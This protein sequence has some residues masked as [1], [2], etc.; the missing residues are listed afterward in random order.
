[1]VAEPPGVLIVVANHD[2]EGG[3][4][5][6]VA[7]LARHQSHRRPVVVLT[8]APTPLPSV[9]PDPTGAIVVR[10]PCL[11]SWSTDRDRVWAS[12]NTAVSVVTAVTAAVACRRR[13]SVVY[14]AGL[15]PE[16]VVAAM[17]GRMLRRSYILDTWLP[18]PIGNVARLRRSPVAP[19]LLRLVGGAKAFVA[20]TAE[21]AGELRACGLPSDRVLTVRQGV[22][23]DHFHPV[24]VAARRRSA[25]DLVGNATG[26]VA[27]CG[28]IDLRQKRLDLL[29]DAWEQADLE[30]WSLVLAGD[31]PDAGR[32]VS[33]GR[34]MTRPPV[35]LGWRRDVAPVLAGAD[36]YVLPTNFEATGRSVL[37][38]MAC[39]LPGLVSATSTYADLRPDGV[40]LVDN[41]AAA[42]AAALTALASDGARREHLGRRARAW[43]EVNGDVGAGRAVIDRLLDE[44]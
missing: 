13:W 41:T 7:D 34:A 24:D 23:L 39:G 3:L 10:V 43:V 29:L 32:I 1:M 22:D 21:I 6:K 14:A 25:L 36:I 15:N 20:E 9:R 11:V 28:R 16:G 2:G 17:A 4:Q 35:H 40:V 19:F 42:W 5:L 31:G 38:G 18:G 33:R 8:W 37:E 27:Y 30:G 12:L 26:V 44:E